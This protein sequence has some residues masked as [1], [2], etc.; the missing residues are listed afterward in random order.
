M[1]DASLFVAGMGKLFDISLK[2]NMLSEKVKAS[3]PRR[4]FVHVL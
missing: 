4:L 2:I 1:S 3:Y